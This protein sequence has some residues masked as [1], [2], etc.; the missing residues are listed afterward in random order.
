LIIAVVLLNIY[1]S[2]SQDISNLI[3]SIIELIAVKDGID[4]GWRSGV[5]N[6][7]TLWNDVMHYFGG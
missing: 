4:R 3:Y 2:S 7:S 1:N 5:I 6:R